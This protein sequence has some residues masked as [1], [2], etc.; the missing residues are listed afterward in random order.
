V[1]ECGRVEI[2][3]RLARAAREEESPAVGRYGSRVVGRRRP[4]DLC[5]TATAVGVDDAEPQSVA[6]DNAAVARPDGERTAGGA[7]WRDQPSE[8]RALYVLNPQS[9]VD[10]N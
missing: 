1:A 6:I 4:A 9:V 5:Y 8:C 2:E 7:S 3:G 10:L